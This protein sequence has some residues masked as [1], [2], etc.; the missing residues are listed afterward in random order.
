VVRVGIVL[1]LC[2][3]GSA[4]NVETPAGTDTDTDTD[5]S[6][7]SDGEA[8]TDGEWTASISETTPPPGSSGSESGSEG[9]ATTGASDC[10]AIEA[11]SAHCIVTDGARVHLVG[12]DTGSV[13]T[14]VELDQAFGASSLA[15]MDG[16]LVGCDDTDLTL[17]RADL[18]TG[19]VTTFDVSCQAVTRHPEGVL[20]LPSTSGSPA[21]YASVD[22]I[23]AGTASETF[24]IEP[25]AARISVADDIMYSAWHSTQ[26]MQVWDL[27]T[28]A[29][30]MDVL[31]E[32]FD[33][34]VFGMAAVGGNLALL[35]SPDTLLLRVH[36]A[37][38]GALLDE[39][40][41]PDLAS[42]QGL[43]CL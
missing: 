8:S 15:W 30:V 38:S 23:V 35:G 7:G 34:W 2:G 12:L 36:D 19:E 16:E 25:A 9:S 3:C 37:G 18:A 10:G 14:L 6:S 29:Y 31:L 13:C 22:A 11:E 1:L 5:A 21:L 33:D 32:D 20:V 28:S 17:R 39:L 4:A 26:A 43:A 24:A 42:P 41:L 27:A 40:P